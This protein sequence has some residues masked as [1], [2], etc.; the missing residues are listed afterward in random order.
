MILSAGV[1]SIVGLFVYIFAHFLVGLFYS[2]C[3]R[4]DPIGH[5]FASYQF[6]EFCIYGDSIWPYRCIPCCRKRD[7][8]DESL[9]DFGF[10][11]SVSFGVFTIT[12]NTRSER[13]LVGICHYQCGDDIYLSW[14][15]CTRKMEAQ[16]F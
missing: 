6:L 5:R 3:A 11:D 12:N 1:L 8:R 10:C 4:I 7:T 15:F 13:N 9:T 16:K 14:N 2:R